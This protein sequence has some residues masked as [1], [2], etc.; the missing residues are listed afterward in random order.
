MITNSDHENGITLVNG[1]T[2]TYRIWCI[3]DNFNK[4][5]F[6]DEIDVVQQIVN[7]TKGVPYEHNDPYLLGPK[8]KINLK[9]DDIKNSFIVVYNPYSTTYK[10]LLKPFRPNSIISF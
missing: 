1:T 7:P 6:N 4:F 2:K 8:R 10:S 3:P 5:L 9:Y